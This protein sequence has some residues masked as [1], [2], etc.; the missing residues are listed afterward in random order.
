[1]MAAS[2]Y[3]YTRSKRERDTIYVTFSAKCERT[4]TVLRAE[5]SLKAK[6]KKEPSLKLDLNGEM[7]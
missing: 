6:N 3:K 7:A 1:M 5:A 2:V 4:Y